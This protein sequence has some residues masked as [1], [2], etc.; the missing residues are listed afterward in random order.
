MTKAET[1]KQRLVS[2]CSDVF[3]WNVTQNAVPLHLTKNFNRPLTLHQLCSSCKCAAPTSL[4][5]Q[6][7]SQKDNRHG[8]RNL[9]LI[10]R[11]FL[12]SLHLTVKT[13]LSNL[14]RVKATMLPPYIALILAPSLNHINKAAHW[15][16]IH[17][18][19]ILLCF[20]NPCKSGYPQ[21][22]SES[23]ISSCGTISPFIAHDGTG[24]R[25]QTLF[26]LCMWPRHCVW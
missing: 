10:K 4:A 5:V 14:H 23:V 8:E 12:R 15:I 21:R 25:L 17:F 20:F 9:S 2:Y 19:L 24:H 16:Y 22:E 1:T 26:I 7:T 6:C 11:R 13:M 18:L 3:N